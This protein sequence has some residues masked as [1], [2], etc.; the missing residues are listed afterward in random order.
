MLTLIRLSGTLH[1]IISR[2]GNGLGH[3]ETNPIEDKSTSVDYPCTVGNI[4]QSHFR[5]TICYWFSVVMNLWAFHVSFASII[6]FKCSIN[7][8]KIDQH[9]P[10]LS[11]HS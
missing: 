9:I 2:A 1:S 4:I 3:I 5:K 10:F 8:L 7:V 6:D 11:V